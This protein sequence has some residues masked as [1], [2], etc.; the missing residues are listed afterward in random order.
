MEDCIW[1]PWQYVKKGL[2]EIIENQIKKAATK[3]SRDKPGFKSIEWSPVLPSVFFL[4][5][6][7]MQYIWFQNLR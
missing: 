6:A 2:H 4:P 5:N 1:Q 7:E 3:C